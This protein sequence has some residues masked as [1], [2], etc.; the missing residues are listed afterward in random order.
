[1]Q[2]TAVYFRDRDAACAWARGVPESMDMLASRLAKDGGADIPPCSM[3]S[4]MSA[5]FRQSGGQFWPWR[6]IA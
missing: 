3:G 6:R 4:G 1:M 5:S 2:L